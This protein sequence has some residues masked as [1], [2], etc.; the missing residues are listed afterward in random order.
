MRIG[1]LG[2]GTLAAALGESWSR[3]GHEVAIGG[4][5]QGKAEK[6]AERLGRGVL[7][8]APREAVIGRDAVLLAVSWDGVEDMLGLVGASEGLLEGTPL[9]D[10][11]NAVAHGVGVLLTEHGESMARRIAELAP[12]AHVVKAF[13]LFPADQWT[14]SSGGGQ[15]GVTVVMCG[16]DS[17]ALRVVGELVRDVGGTPAIL[18]A[19]DRVRQSEEVAGFVIGLAFA[20]FDPNSAVPR[21]PSSAA[22]S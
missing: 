16:D 7:A 3:A 18:G 1:I 22:T 12:G 13:H 6:L 8:V 21:V 11:T 14:S 2:T 20:G 19:L 9:I 5:S 15:S 17:A 10:P 4:R